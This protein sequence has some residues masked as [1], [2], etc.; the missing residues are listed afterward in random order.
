MTGIDLALAGAGGEVLAV[1]LER[2]ELVLGVLRRDAVRT[3]HLGERAQHL[4]AIDAEAVAHRQQQVL[5]G[6][7]VVAQVGLDA[8][9]VVE[10][11][12]DLAT[13]ARLVAAVGLGQTGDRLV[14]T[15][16][17]HQRRLAEAGEH[18]GDDRVVLAG[19][20]GEE[21]VGGQL[22]VGVPL[23][24]IDRRADR[25]LRLQ[26]PLLGV[27]GHGSKCTEAART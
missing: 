4:L 6:Q 21:V 11:G 20:G 9:G 24:Q 16:A 7:E 1:A 3:A 17:D 13:E 23:G 12:V 15:V 14:G 8:L 22:R 2:L 18:G 25:L 19:D 27:E 26:R 10:D 5:D